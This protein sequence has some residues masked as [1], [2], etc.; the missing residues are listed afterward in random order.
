[1][2]WLTARGL[3]A[4]E[5]EKTRADEVTDWNHMMLTAKTV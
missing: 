4:K 5:N 2:F 3:E 1:M